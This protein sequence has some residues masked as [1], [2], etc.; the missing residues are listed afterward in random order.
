MNKCNFEAE[1]TNKSN[2]KKHY[3]TDSAY[4]FTLI[5]ELNH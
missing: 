3:C 2:N 5:C 4:P 1:L